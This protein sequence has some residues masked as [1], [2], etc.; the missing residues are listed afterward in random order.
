ML[1][2][3]LVLNSRKLWQI[4]KIEVIRLSGDEMN[5]G[6]GMLQARFSQSQTAH[7]LRVSQSIVSKMWNLFQIDENVL[8]LH[9]GCREHS[10]TQAQDW[11][12][13][14]QARSHLFRNTTML[15]NHFQKP[16]V[17]SISKQTVRTRCFMLDWGHGGLQYTSHCHRNVCNGR[18][19]MLHG[20]LMTGPQIS[21]HMSL[22]FVWTSWTGGLGIRECQMNVFLRYVL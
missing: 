21:S 6:T 5:S 19:L 2:S 11:F 20:Q 13:V 3:K 4:G 1:S 8:H 12:I 7:I 15:R 9:A 17:V 16:T 14:F 22:G 18:E 10:T